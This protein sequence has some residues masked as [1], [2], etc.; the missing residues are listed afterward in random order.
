MRTTTNRGDVRNSKPVTD[1]SFYG[2]L[3]ALVIIG[4]FVIIASDMSSH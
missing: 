1:W 3:I 4:T 2:V